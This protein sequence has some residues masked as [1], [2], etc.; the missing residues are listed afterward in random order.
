M[1]LSDVA[2]AKDGVAPKSFDVSAD[3]KQ[4]VT[5][6]LFQNPNSNSVEIAAAVSQALAGFAP[7]SPPGVDKKGM[8]RA[9]W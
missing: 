6:L 9:R 8:T 5:V 1:H 3:G 4:A 2:D 7:P